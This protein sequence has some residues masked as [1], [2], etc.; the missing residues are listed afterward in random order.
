[1]TFLQITRQSLK[2]LLS[3]KFKQLKRMQH[4]Q[5]TSSHNVILLVTMRLFNAPTI[6]VAS[7]RVLEVSDIML[8]Y[9]T[10]I[11]SGPGF[12]LLREFI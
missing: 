10:H 2:Y 5:L 7:A 12:A 6:L 9:S 8:D 1:M 4:P 11:D 3:A